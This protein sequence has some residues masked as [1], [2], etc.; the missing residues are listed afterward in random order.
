[1]ARSPAVTVLLVA[2]TATGPTTMRLAALATTLTGPALVTTSRSRQRLSRRRA[3][4][5]LLHRHMLD[6]RWKQLLDS[7]QQILIFRRHQ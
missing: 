2:V 3:D 1:M 4:F 7:A 5:K 6:R